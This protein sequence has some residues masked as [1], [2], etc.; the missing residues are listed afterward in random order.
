MSDNSQTP[1]AKRPLAWVWQYYTRQQKV[2]QS[3]N[4]YIEATCNYCNVYSMA[5]HND[6]MVKHLSEV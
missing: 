5:H 4:S 6:R 3:G 2:N 1:K